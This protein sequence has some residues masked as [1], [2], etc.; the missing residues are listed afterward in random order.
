MVLKGSRITDLARWT[1]NVHRAEKWLVVVVNSRVCYQS[2]LPCDRNT[3]MSIVTLKI[4]YRFHTVPQVYLRSLPKVWQI[5][6]KK[7]IPRFPERSRIVCPLA[8]FDFNT[9]REFTRHIALGTKGFT[10]ER[11]VVSRILSFEGYEMKRK[12]TH[13]R[14]FKKIFV[15]TGHLL[16]IQ[17]GFEKFWVR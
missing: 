2:H 17:I 11:S 6:T 1:C 12:D 3:K 14:T 4:D 9:I 10:L 7:P 16:S 13:K 5:I 8:S 15:P